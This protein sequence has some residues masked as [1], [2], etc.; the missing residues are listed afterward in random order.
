MKNSIT[1]EQILKDHDP[2][3]QHLAE[4]L[5]ELIKKNIPE[6]VEKAYPGGHAIGYLHPKAGY[7][8]NIFPDSDKITLA[9]EHGASFYDPDHLLKN[10]PTSSKQVRYFEVRSE[11][12]IKEALIADFLAQALFVKGK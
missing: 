2:H 5:R 1:P 4:K 12:D 11:E 8:C 10:P 7:I 9:F 6:A 3:I